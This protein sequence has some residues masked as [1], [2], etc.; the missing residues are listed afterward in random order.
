VISFPDLTFDLETKNALLKSAK[1]LFNNKITD[2]MRENAVFDLK[3]HLTDMKKTIQTEMNKEL[4]KGV[5]LSGKVESLSIHK[6]YPNH[7][8]LVIRVNTA[9]DMKLAM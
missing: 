7:K 2:A 5:K 4:T 1:W 6:I 8:N 3:P 9:G